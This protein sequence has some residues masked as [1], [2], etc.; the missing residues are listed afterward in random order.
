M[1]RYG[2]PDSFP[3]QSNI[4]KL[5]LISDMNL[6]NGGDGSPPF[7]IIYLQMAVSMVQ[8]DWVMNVPREARKK[9]QSNIYHVM[10]RGINRQ[11]IFEDDEDRRFF[12]HLLR[13]IKALSDFRLHAFCLMSNHVHFLIEPAGEPLETVFKRLGVSYAGWYNRKY[14][15][16]GHLFQDRFRS[17]AVE[18]DGYYLTVLR[19]ILQNPM[20]AGFEGRPGTYRWS[21]YLAY[22]KG[23]GSVTDTAYALRLFESRADFLEYIGAANGDCVMDEE[24]SDP[25]IRKAREKEIML[26]VTHCSS[27]PEFQQLDKSLQKAYIRELHQ[28]YLSSGQ[29]ARLTGIPKTT[30]YRTVKESDPGAETEDPELILREQDE[31][32]YDPFEIW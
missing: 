22:E 17:E 18:T 14:Q 20:K 26:R 30:V 19:Y 8:S 27:V 4:S 5:Y 16:T 13:K 7:R 21:S 3:K 25:R 10:L 28:A 1:V 23:T 2:F 31:S 6:W 24:S 15:R 12:L 32:A 29:I 9:S 11:V